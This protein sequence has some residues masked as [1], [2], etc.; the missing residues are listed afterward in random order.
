MVPDVLVVTERHYWT[1]EQ[2][3]HNLENHPSDWL[4]FEHYWWPFGSVSV[5][6]AFQCIV[7]GKLQNY[8]YQQDKVFCQ[9]VRKYRD[10][11][12]PIKYP[13]HDPTTNSYIY[14]DKPYTD[15]PKYWFRNQLPY[16][17]QEIL[18]WIRKEL[19]KSAK[20]I[21]IDGRFV[22]FMQ[23]I[24]LEILNQMQFIDNL[25]FPLHTSTYFNAVHYLPLVSA[26]PIRINDIE[27]CFQAS[28]TLKLG[29][30]ETFSNYFK[31]INKLGLMIQDE[32]YNGRFPV[33]MCVESRI[34][35]QSPCPLAANYSTEK[36]LFVYL[37]ILSLSYSPTWEAFGNC[38]FQMVKSI[39][40][41]VKPSLGKQWTFIDGIYEHLQTVCNEGLVELKKLQKEYDPKERFMFKDVAKLFENLN[42]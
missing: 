5:D 14:A 9:I 21:D 19:L 13:Y 3:K 42:N 37:E 20:E 40:P 22:P 41:N 35:A 39:D 1:L 15:D 8:D 12:G 4:S 34:C 38:F 33:S 24:V 30:N 17:R 31:A 32:A 2:M 25:R 6:D 16:Y 7:T 23:V 27:L 18:L 10:P 29:E 36:K 26:L 28:P 11:N